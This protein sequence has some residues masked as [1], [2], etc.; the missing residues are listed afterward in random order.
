[1]R[2]WLG[3]GRNHHRYGVSPAVI[4]S[5]RREKNCQ[6]RGRDHRARPVTARHLSRWRSERT[7]ANK[8]AYET[9]MQHMRKTVW[10]ARAGCAATLLIAAGRALDIQS[11]G[12]NIPSSPRSLISASVLRDYRSFSW[13]DMPRVV[14]VDRKRYRRNEKMAAPWRLAAPASR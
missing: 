4:N 5:I 13:L 1:M 12:S 11:V 3:V 8:S 7:N 2:Q 10:A 6:M 14:S 9:E